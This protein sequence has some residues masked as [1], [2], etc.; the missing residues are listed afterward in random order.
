MSSGHAPSGTNWLCEL[1]AWD[2]GDPA[3]EPS[4]GNPAG[5]EERAAPLGHLDIHLE[6]PVKN[7]AFRS[8]PHKCT[9]DTGWLSGLTQDFLHCR[10]I[11][12]TS[13]GVEGRRQ[14]S[15]HPLPPLSDSGPRKH[16]TKGCLLRPLLL[17]GAGPYARQ[18]PESSGAQSPPPKPHLTISYHTACS[19]SSSSSSSE[20]A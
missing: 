14:H 17:P 19:H 1:E 7:S 10:C 13:L 15:C 6:L 18:N 3:G 4:P 8:L 11:P 5:L 20:P 16:G 2:N 12:Q 9:L